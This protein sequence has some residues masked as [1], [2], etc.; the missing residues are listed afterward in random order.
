MITCWSSLTATC[1]CSSLNKLLSF[2]FALLFL[3]FRLERSCYR[4]NATADMEIIEKNL[5]KLY[6]SPAVMYERRI[7]LLL[8]VVFSLSLLTPLSTHK[9]QTCSFCC[10][11]PRFTTAAS[12]NVVF[13][14]SNLREERL[15]FYRNVEVL[16]CFTLASHSS[17]SQFGKAQKLAWLFIYQKFVYSFSPF[18]PC[19]H[20]SSPVF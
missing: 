5:K 12:L 20:L 9:K 11:L 2:L 19:H 10:E 18:R 4:P 8:V 17:E 6:L 14:I 16:F 15:L 3:N 7:Y 13:S 1:T